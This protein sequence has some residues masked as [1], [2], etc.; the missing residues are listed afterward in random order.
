MGGRKLFHLIFTLV[1]LAFYGLVYWYLM[2]LDGM[3][4]VSLL[5]TTIALTIVYAIPIVYPKRGKGYGKMTV[6]LYVVTILYAAIVFVVSYM[7]SFLYTLDGTEKF[8]GLVMDEKFYF[9]AHTIGLAIELVL[10]FM[11][12]ATPKNA[13]KEEPLPFYDEPEVQEEPIEV[14]D[15][16]TD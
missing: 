7:Y 4:Y 3:Q 5:F 6:K 2:P 8:L 12:M 14:Q 11:N 10:I 15:D 13:T 1:L 9:L 16:S